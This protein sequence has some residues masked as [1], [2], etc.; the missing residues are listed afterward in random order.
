MIYPPHFTQK[1]GFDHILKILKE[2]CN[3]PLTLKY[4]D[5]I[6]FS[7]IY[8]EIHRALSE[9]EEMRQILENAQGFPHRELPYL[10]EE[11]EHLR[12]EGTFAD[13]E[14]LSELKSAINTIFESLSFFR[15]SSSK[16]YPLLSARASLFHPDISIVKRIDQIMDEKGNI[17]DSASQKLGEI[18]RERV[19]LNA[20]VG[21]KL[22][23]V[24]KQ[25]KS[26]GWTESDVEPGIRNGRLV[27]PVGASHKRKLKGFI[28]DESSSG[29]TVY[30]EPAEVF[31]I[32]NQVRELD[33]AE[34]REIV[35]I[36]T[37]FATY[38]RPHIESL[39]ETFVFMAFLG[40]LKAKAR[41]AIKTGAIMPVLEN[42]CGFQ[43]FEARH[44]LL[45]LS[46]KG[47]GKSI[48]PLNIGLNEGE[49]ILIISGPN[50]G[51][52]SVCLKTV[53]LLQYMLQCGLLVPMK[54]GSVAGI[55]ENLFIDIGDEQSLE[56]DLSTYSSHLMNMKYFIDHSGEKTLF[57]IDE[58]GV[59]TEPQAGGAIAEAILGRLNEK[60]A[61]GVVTTHY[62][63]LKL[64][65][66]KNECMINGAMLYDQANMEPLFILQTGKPGSSFAFEIARKIG[67]DDELLIEAGEKTGRTQMDF[68]EELKKLEVEKAI[69][70]KKEQEFRVADDFL[71][72]M[73]TKYGELIKKQELR[74][75]EM[76]EKAR[77]EA[78]QIIDKANKVVEHTIKEIRENQADKGKTKQLREELKSE[79][80]HLSNELKADK[81]N[82]ILGHSK[83]VFKDKKKDEVQVTPE[84]V[85]TTEIA[86]GDW[87]KLAG[88]SGIGQVEAVKGK[89]VQVSFGTIKLK[90]L[91]DRLVKA[92]DQ[93][94]KQGKISRPPSIYGKYIDEIHT[95]LEQF[96][97][98]LDL[99]G[100][101]AE[102]A[103]SELR[104]YID[105]AILLDIFEVR[106]LHGKGDGI[107]RSMVR[108]YI[109]RVPEVKEF[110]DELL[111]L[112]GHGITVVKFNL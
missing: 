74:Q 57:L 14:M 99:R 34:R 58:F 49:R 93:E 112:G 60:K 92:S 19:V 61:Y 62:A 24:L 83:K 91:I 81:A 105:D 109:S 84:A 15:N 32:N 85:V 8:G 96:H 45:Y 6:H 1:S 47:Q 86:I 107:L 80:Q 4:I 16:K 73:I 103:L 77:N 70:L 36:L 30:I 65:P 102:E 100:M 41:L 44:P 66:G 106:I 2:N 40:F 55:F 75:K 11:L 50:A 89:E 38:L 94:L 90:C 28:H 54:E 111:E 59:G 108:D 35:K 78:S 29:N 87:V 43:W 56:N 13:V 53:G 3:N 104:K 72:D 21:K 7:S 26:E 42:R 63:N 51:G 52:K 48:V 31:E 68:E 88:Q 64:M 18:R 110:R 101:R 17:R 20:E 82:D 27:I 12:I 33:L 10:N 25:A 22:N 39:L 95:K 79:A 76:L 69:L 98:T 23:K 97:I 37:E 71:A 46:H 9:T 5:E 67:F